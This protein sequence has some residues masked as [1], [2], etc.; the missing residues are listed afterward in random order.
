MT[1]QTGIP[2]VKVQKVSKDLAVVTSDCH[3]NE[4]HCHYN[5]YCLVVK[6]GKNRRERE[7]ERENLMHEW[8]GMEW[9]GMER[10]ETRGRR[11]GG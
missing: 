11:T 1:F 10:K 5:D 4:G 2:E 9:N 3:L 8:N 7:R 6:E